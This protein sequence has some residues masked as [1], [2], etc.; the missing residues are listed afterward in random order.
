MDCN[1]VGEVS[2]RHSTRT[3]Q[4]GTED[5]SQARLGMQLFANGLRWDLAGVKG[6]TDFSPRSGLVFG[7]TKEIKA[8]TP[9]K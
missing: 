6:L 7:I 2:G 4:I 9:A 8:F 3:P 1:I 5:I